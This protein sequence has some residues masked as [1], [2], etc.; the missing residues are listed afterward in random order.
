VL[1]ALRCAYIPRPLDIPRGSA[2]HFTNSIRRLADFCRMKQP[3]TKAERMEIRR[4]IGNRKVHGPPKQFYFR[5]QRLFPHACFECRK[6][7]KIPEESTARCP[8]CGNT[9]H[10]MGRA[11]RTPRRSDKQ[12]WLKVRKLWMAGFR[13]FVNTHWRKP[14]PEPFP[15]RLQD[16]ED[17]IRRNQD[18][19]FRAVR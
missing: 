7:W 10:W 6:S 8:E 1:W 13:F 17:F 14:E 18:H 12:Q 16:V 5:G 15:E 2:H 4:S 3:I 9:L 11:F 19:P